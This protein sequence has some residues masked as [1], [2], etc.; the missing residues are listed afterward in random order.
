MTPVFVEP[1]TCVVAPHDDVVAVLRVE[2][3]A[4]LVESSP[5]SNAYRI[6]IDCS[7]ASVVLAVTVEG[8]SSRT[9]RTEL[10]GAP[11]NV[12]PRIVA[13]AIAEIVRDLDG[14]AARA[15]A[16]ERPAEPAPASPVVD[17]SPPAR[18]V[19]PRG[20]RGGGTVYLGALGQA[21]SFRLDGRWLLG[22]GLRFEYARDIFCAGTDA[23]LLTADERVSQ[24]TAQ[25][26]LSYASPYVGLGGSSGP[27]QVRLGAGYALGAAR[28]SGHAT[29]PRAG[30]A[31]LTGAWTAPY[32]FAQV[33]LALGDSLRVDLR[34]Q[35]G[36]VT[37]SVV[38]EVEGGGDVNLAGLWT[39]VQVGAALSL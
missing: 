19:T 18:D 37:A 4:Q 5:P 32:A 22:G 2:L 21:T 34:G 1:G 28:L 17:V 31:T 11:S 16:A 35:A 14:E 36:W 8:R 3:A 10:G 9:Y 29:D 23:V 33:A 15:A 12:R 25:V 7:G 6:T 24:G 38:G 39:S 13:L 27:F 26:L 30:A 20:P